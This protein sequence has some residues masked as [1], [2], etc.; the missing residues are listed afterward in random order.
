MTDFGVMQDRGRISN[1]A[2]FHSNVWVEEWLRYMVVFITFLGP[3]VAVKYGSV[4][5]RD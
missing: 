5:E 4:S 3:G 2:F 1:Y